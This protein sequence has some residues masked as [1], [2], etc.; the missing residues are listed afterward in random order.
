MSVCFQQHRLDLASACVYQALVDLRRGGILQSA[1]QCSAWSLGDPAQ[2]LCLSWLVSF[3]GSAVDLES[4]VWC[5]HIP[6]STP[7]VIS[8]WGS[9]ISSF[10]CCARCPSSQGHPWL[11]KPAL[12]L[13]CL[14][15]VAPSIPADSGSFACGF[16][17]LCSVCFLIPLLDSWGKSFVAVLV[18]LI[19]CVWQA[20]G[21]RMCAL[22]VGRLEKNQSTCSNATVGRPVQN[23]VRSFL[24]R[25]KLT[26]LPFLLLLALD[27]WPSLLGAMLDGLSWCK[28]CLLIV[29]CWSISLMWS[30]LTVARLTRLCLTPLLQAVRVLSTLAPHGSTHMPRRWLVLTKDPTVQTS[31]DQLFWN[32]NLQCAIGRWLPVGCATCPASCR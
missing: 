7:C 13:S 23:C 4:L 27:F 28:H 24:C 3:P 2:S 14:Y 15:Q 17:W 19:V 12:G 6:L 10:C 20:C 22:G 31:W 32:A 9:Q 21:I 5:S 8:A 11:A 29:L 18:Q 26:G 30:T 1:F 25:R 16:S